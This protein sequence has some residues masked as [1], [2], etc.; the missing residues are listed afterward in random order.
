[1]SYKEK[2][3]QNYLHKFENRENIEQ[4]DRRIDKLTLSLH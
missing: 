2:K 4:D 1:M 3:I